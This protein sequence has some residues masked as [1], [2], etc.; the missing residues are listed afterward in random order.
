MGQA[1]GKTINKETLRSSASKKLQSLFFILLVV[2][3][4]IFIELR[5]LPGKKHS[6]MKLQR[7]REV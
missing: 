6:Q 2:L 7:L 3:L 1:A 5:I 4:C